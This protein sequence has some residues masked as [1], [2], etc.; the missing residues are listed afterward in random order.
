[1]SCEYPPRER[2]F[3]EELRT[4]RFR[5]MRMTQRAFAER[6]GLSYGALKDLERGHTQPTRAMRVLT[7][8][9][10]IAPDAVEQAARLVANDIVRS[11]AARRGHRWGR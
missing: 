7:L 10:A 1:M 5:G 4:L 3:R 11:D 6:F 8:A 9:I 2:S